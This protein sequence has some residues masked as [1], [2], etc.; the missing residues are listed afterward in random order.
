MSFNER[1]KVKIKWKK[2]IAWKEVGPYLIIVDVKSQ[3]QIRSLNSS[4]AA[5]WKKCNGEFTY[6]EVLKALE[7]EF[8][9]DYRTLKNDMD[10]LLLELVAE[11]LVEYV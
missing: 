4:A 2:F 9:I 6:K 8:D 3:Q 11:Q 5:F 7:Q 10:E 1:E